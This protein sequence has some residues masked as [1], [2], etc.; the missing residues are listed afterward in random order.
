MRTFLECAALQSRA[1]PRWLAADRGSYTYSALH[2]E[3]LDSHS[4]GRAGVVYGKCSRTKA[5]AGAGAPAAIGNGRGATSGPHETMATTACATAKRVR[6]MPPCLGR[7]SKHAGRHMSRRATAVTRR[8]GTPQRGVARWRPRR[9]RRRCG[10]QRRRTIAARSAVDALD[11][12]E[13]GNGVD[14]QSEWDASVHEPQA[15]N[16]WR[17]IVGIRGPGQQMCHHTAHHEVCSEMRQ[18]VGVTLAAEPA[19]DNHRRRTAHP[20]EGT[21]SLAAN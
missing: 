20:N 14:A 7:A 8:R 4:R 1:S 18:S 11:S 13:R 12:I 5:V 17:A 10:R 6:A 21:A 3:P 19:L 16:K 2:A 9:R 15:L